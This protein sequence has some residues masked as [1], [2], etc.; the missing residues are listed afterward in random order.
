MT[1]EERKALVSEGFALRNS[2]ERD[3]ERL[4]KIKELLTGAA[5]GKNVEFHGNA[6]EIAA[7]SFHPSMSRK[8]DPL[9]ETEAKELCGSFFNKLF[10]RAPIKD[11]GKVAAALLPVESSVKLLKLLSGPPAPRVCFKEAS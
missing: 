8:L 4:E 11:F 6:G 10:C 5:N 7:I 2:I 1:V 9:Q 3:M